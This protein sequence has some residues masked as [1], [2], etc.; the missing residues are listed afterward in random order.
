[1]TECYLR[2]IKAAAICSIHDVIHAE[3]D[4]S[5]NTCEDFD[6]NLSEGLVIKFGVKM[7]DM[8]TNNTPSATNATTRRVRGGTGFPDWLYWSPCYTTF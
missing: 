6:T 7:Y 2:S 3:T 8:V 1:M 5:R 4:S